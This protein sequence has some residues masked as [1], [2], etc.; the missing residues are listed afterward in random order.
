MCVPQQFQHVL[1][2]L[3]SYNPVW[4]GGEISVIMTLP[5][6]RREVEKSWLT[7]LLSRGLL[8]SVNPH[9]R[10]TG[11]CALFFPL[12]KEWL[13]FPEADRSRCSQM[14]PDCERTWKYCQP[15][16][17]SSQSPLHLQGHLLFSWHNSFHILYPGKNEL[18]KDEALIICRKL[19][20]YSAQGRKWFFALRTSKCCAVVATSWGGTVRW[21]LCTV[22]WGEGKLMQSCQG[23]GK[24]INIE[25]LVSHPM[26]RRSAARP[27]PARSLSWLQTPICPSSL[28]CMPRVS[29]WT[30]CALQALCKGRLPPETEGY[31]Q[32]WFA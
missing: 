16:R 22:C 21:E 19:A 32:H 9:R 1:N 18:A 11:V 6:P 31:E 14:Y 4:R 10:H 20:F 2:M 23:C 5:I 13:G 12:L 8:W 17:A 29:C 3:A 28:P 26:A 25:Q 24:H 30:H 7:L 27:P 15:M